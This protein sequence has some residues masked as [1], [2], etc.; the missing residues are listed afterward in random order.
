[1]SLDENWIWY[2]LTPASVP[3]GARISAGKSG[4]VLMSLPSSA[5]VS[6]NC[7]PASCIPSPLSP[8]KRIVTDGSL[9]MVRWRIDADDSAVAGMPG[10][11][12]TCTLT[13]E[14]GEGTPGEGTVLMG[15]PMKA[16]AAARHHGHP[17]AADGLATVLLESPRQSSHGFNQGDNS[18]AASPGGGQVIKTHL[19]DLPTISASTEVKA[20]LKPQGPLSNLL[21][22]EG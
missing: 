2:P 11:T 13:D 9:V 18:P 12:A 22:Q 7:I 14:T 19:Y 20:L 5:D 16:C 3:A 21:R 10:G 1:M 17:L 6:V 4:S 8:A 15:C